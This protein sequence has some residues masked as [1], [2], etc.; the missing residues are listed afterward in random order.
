[1]PWAGFDPPTIGVASRAGYH[2]TMPRPQVLKC[3]LIVKWILR[4]RFRNSLFVPIIVTIAVIK[5]EHKQQMKIKER[6]QQ[7]HWAN[8]FY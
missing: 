7:N 6:K 2:C 8:A 4:F 1:M 5:T 3:L